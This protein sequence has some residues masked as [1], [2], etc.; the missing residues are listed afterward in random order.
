[1]IDNAT[2]LENVKKVKR[3]H[4]KMLLTKPNVVG[5]GIGFRIQGGQQTG[6]IGIVVMVNKKLPAS[7]LKPTEM[8][9]LEIEGVPVDVQEKGAI[10]AQY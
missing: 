5:V 1:M 10:H 2:I 7:Q 4:E 8:I 9:P 3:A 6:H